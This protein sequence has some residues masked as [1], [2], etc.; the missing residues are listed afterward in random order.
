MA[1]FSVAAMNGCAPGPRVTALIPPDAIAIAATDD[2]AARN[3]VKGIVTELKPLGETTALTVAVDGQ[4]LRLRVGAREASSRNMC[5]GDALS[6]HL[7][8]TCIHLMPA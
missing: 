7:D 8:P 4:R 3:V 6:V 2:A 5:I 1:S